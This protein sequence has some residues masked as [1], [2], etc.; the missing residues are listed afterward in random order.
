MWLKCSEY[1]E[2]D[3]VW[4]WEEGRAGDLRNQS[5][6]FPSLL[7]PVEDFGGFQKE[8]IFP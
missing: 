1:V 2:K 8:N 7:S 5:E 6:A 3:E 4:E